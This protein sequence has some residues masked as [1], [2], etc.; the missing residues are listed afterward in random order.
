MPL[1]V[2]A[3]RWL[4]GASGARALLFMGLFTNFFVGALY[5]Q[6]VRGFTAFETGLAFLPTTL[7]IGV[8]SAGLA[9]RLMARVGPRN[10]LVAGGVGLI[11]APGLLSG[12]GPPPCPCPSPRA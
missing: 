5:L 4:A 8:L 3:I 10:L 9:A 7:M 12:V 1:R 11:A 6:H 2:L